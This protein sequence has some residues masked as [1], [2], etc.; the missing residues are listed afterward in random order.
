M[1]VKLLSLC[2]LINRRTSPS[3]FLTASR[4]LGEDLQCC[5]T[6]SIASSEVRIP[7]TFAPRRLINNFDD[8]EKCRATSSTRGFNIRP[9]VWLRA[10]IDERG[11]LLLR[12]APTGRKCRAQ[13]RNLRFRAS[14]RPTHSTEE[15][16]SRVSPRTSSTGFRPCHGRIWSKLIT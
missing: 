7:P 1:R 16:L 2:V 6:A 11:N 14:H 12:G 15:E 9:N 13:R 3:A 8:S 4:V 10:P 5:A